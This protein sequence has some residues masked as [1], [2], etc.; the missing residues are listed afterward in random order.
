[1][2]FR[3]KAFKLA[4]ITLVWLIA[5]VL[6][7]LHEYLFLTNYP[8][9]L[10][11]LPMQD[12]HFSKN[13]VAASIALGFGG[14]L[15][16][17]LELFLFKTFVVRT[18]FWIGLIL[19]M[20]IYSGVLFVIITGTSWLFNTVLSGN[21]LFSVA[22]WEKTYHFITSES[23]WHPVTPFLVLALISIFF[24]QLTE[25]FS[26][27]ELLRLIS[28]KYFHPKEESRIFMF[29]DLNGSTTLAEQLG[30]SRFYQLLNDFFHDLA[31]AIET[32]R[33][34][35]VEYVGDEIVICWKM[36][37]GLNQSRCLKCFFDIEME[38]QS[39][40]ATYL[41]KFGVVPA[42]KAAVH[43]GPVIIGEMGKIKK[44][45]KYSG[46]VLNTTSRVEQ[47]CNRIEAKLAA[48]GPLIMQLESTPYPAERVGDLELRGK[49]ET[50]P[51]Y[52]IA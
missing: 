16:G 4:L 12:Y 44:S 19:K 40:R 28:G 30:N 31:E 7:T 13:L 50:V 29:L 24:I 35:V 8:G 23:F 1:M 15:L 33:G 49:A 41:E 42:F 38:I 3:P 51:V 14:L 27:Q 52:R 25:R 47:M 21:G 17:F 37:D 48:T 34:E 45:I 2:F 32:N 22:G 20:V 6:I 11:T 9:V 18:K 5:G 10:E 46:D 26:I 36:N 43:C 39:K